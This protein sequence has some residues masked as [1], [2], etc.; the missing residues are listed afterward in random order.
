MKTKFFTIALFALLSFS[1][2]SCADED[3]TPTVDASVLLESDLKCECEGGIID[4]GYEDFRK[5]RPTRP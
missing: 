5:T 1:F 2:F 3:V 4:D